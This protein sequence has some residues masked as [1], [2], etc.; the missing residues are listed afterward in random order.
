[1]ELKHTKA[2]WLIHTLNLEQQL[3]KQH[4]CHGNA[5][6]SAPTQPCLQ[7]SEGL[8][9][10]LT[11]TGSGFC[12][13]LHP[14]AGH[15][16]KTT[17]PKL[18]PRMQEFSPV[19]MCVHT[20]HSKIWNPYGQGRR[21]WQNHTHGSK[22]SPLQK[23]AKAQQRQHSSSVA[24]SGTGQWNTRKFA[25][26]GIFGSCSRT[27]CLLNPMFKVSKKWAKNAC[28]VSCK[29]EGCETYMLSSE[30]SKAK[31]SFNYKGKK[32]K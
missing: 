29:G 26:S 2:P 13:T 21:H 3:A 4:A 10:E 6:H 24:G 1:M 14:S 28:S 19:I 9:A 12:L 22:Q 32:M 16:H 5:P 30:I 17:A 31:S 15:L 8:V 7:G 18:S 23:A 20:R 27:Y 11:S 25:T